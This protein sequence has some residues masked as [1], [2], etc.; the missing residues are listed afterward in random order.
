MKYAGFWPRFWSGLIDFL[1]FIPVVVVDVWASGLS[2]QLAMLTAVVTSML[3]PAYC[4]YFH[5]RYGQTL[6]KMLND[7]KVTRLDG[8]NVGFA[9]AFYRH[10][11]ELFFGV[12]ICIAEI[13][14]YLSISD[15]TYAAAPDWRVRNK[16]IQHSLPPW[17]GIVDILFQVWM[18][19]ELI[20]LLFNEKK[21]ALHDFIAG[22]V[23]IHINRTRQAG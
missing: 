10:F 3:Y 13:A 19:S 9:V 14:M 21:R 17:Y 15:S 18:V 4:I 5:G 22:T 6:G 23:V 11:V 20:I 8:T 1:V 2:R 12:L 16:L 7:I